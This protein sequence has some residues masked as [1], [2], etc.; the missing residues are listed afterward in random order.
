MLAGVLTGRESP[1]MFAAQPAAVALHDIQGAGSRSPFEGAIVTP[2]CVPRFD[3]NPERLRVDSDGQPGA[4][5]INVPAGTVLRNL[6]GVLDY[7]FQ[8]YT[9]LPDPSTPPS[10]TAPPAPGMVRPASAD[11][12]IVASFNLQRFFDSTDDPTVSDVVLTAAAFQTRLRKASLYIRL[13]LWPPIIG[14]QEVENLATLQALAAT[15]NRDAREAREL[16]PRYEAYLEEGN[17]PGGIDVGVLVDLAR[18][19]MFQVVQEGK[20]DLFR[21]PT[22]GQLERLN[23]RPPLVLRARVFFPGDARSM[24]VIVNHLRSLIDIESPTSGP[25]VRAKR[26]GQAEFLAALVN[27]RLAADPGERILVIGDFNAHEFSDGYVDV[28][29]T[30]RGAPAP[31]DQTVLA[32]RDVLDPDLANLI[33]TTPA[34]ERYSYVFDGTAETLDHMLASQAFLPFVTAFAHVRGNADAPEIW[35]SDGNRPERISDHDPAL[36]YIRVR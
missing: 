35:R 12:F 30:I 8:S 14:V 11:E 29:G 4:P 23:D 22:T 2:C 20:G 27:R 33:D 10:V 25:R 21:S 36:V 3:G 28:L 5:A 6:V 31:R 1:L 13:M 16:K 18:V 24:T 32:T 19:E 17:D 15:L 9:I 34:D 7:G 26:A